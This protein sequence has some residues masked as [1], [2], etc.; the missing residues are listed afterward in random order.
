MITVA[1]TIS[2]YKFEP[3]SITLDEY[4][5]D[6]KIIKC[7]QKS[8]SDNVIFVAK[9]NHDFVKII[10]DALCLLKPSGMVKSFQ[11]IL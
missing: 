5:E 11:K 6:R 8:I 2:S 4:C 9:I 7:D 1:P 3:G 10:S